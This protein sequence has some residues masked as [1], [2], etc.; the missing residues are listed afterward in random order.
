MP[1]DSSGRRHDCATVVEAFTLAYTPRIVLISESKDTAIHSSAAARRDRGRRRR[2]SLLDAVFTADLA[3]FGG[4]SPTRL[5]RRHPVTSQD[6]VRDV[7]RNFNADGFGS[8]YRS[9]LAAA[10]ARSTC[11][12]P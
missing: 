9:T 3:A 6:Q 7:I 10:R 12:A 11:R 5:P 8:L 2:V 1:T 4:Q